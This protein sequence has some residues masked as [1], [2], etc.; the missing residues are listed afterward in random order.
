MTLTTIATTFLASAFYF[1]LC[2]SIS[3]MHFNLYL[4]CAQLDHAYWITQVNNSKL[5][6]KP[7]KREFACLYPVNEFCFNERQIFDWASLRPPNGQ[8]TTSASSPISTPWATLCIWACFYFMLP[9]FE[10]NPS[11]NNP[12]KESKCKP[13]KCSG[14]PFLV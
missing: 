12:S 4:Y 5:N 10:L 13:T 1:S 11:A 14:W 6:L 3:I 7:D 9:L 8:F 2:L